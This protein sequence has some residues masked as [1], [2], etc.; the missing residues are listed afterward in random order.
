MDWTKFLNKLVVVSIRDGSFTKGIL[1]SAGLQFLEIRSSN[2]L[3]LIAIQDIV[4]VR[5]A[6]A[7]NG[8]SATER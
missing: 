3:R 2:N 8:S 6:E 4:S 7:S 1:T 5:L